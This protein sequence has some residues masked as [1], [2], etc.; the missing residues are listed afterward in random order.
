MTRQRS[1]WSQS[2]ILWERREYLLER[3]GYSFF[4]VAELKKG[5]GADPSPSI[6]ARLNQKGAFVEKRADA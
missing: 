1:S 5:S 6:H 4:L 3:C 2:P